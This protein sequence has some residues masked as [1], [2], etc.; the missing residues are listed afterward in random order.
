[1][2]SF[3]PATLVD[4]AQIVS[5]VA[6]AAA[7]VVSLWLAARHPKPKLHAYV[8]N[9]A[10]GPAEGRTVVCTLYNEGTAPTAINYVAPV[11]ASRW[12]PTFL[13]AFLCA[14]GWVPLDARSPL[15]RP[16]GKLV[17]LVDPLSEAVCDLTL[18]P[19]H[20]DALRRGQL[21]LQVAHTGFRS[22][23]EL[24]RVKPFLD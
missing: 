3:W 7:V 2:Q 23:P 4:Y 14:R 9:Q 19:E 13:V 17:G 18:W 5:A 24:L 8:R 10:V 11:I 1:M 15:H 22:R 12:C 16:R 20:F 21:V 6:T